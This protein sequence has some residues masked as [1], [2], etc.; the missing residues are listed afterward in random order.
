MRFERL[1]FHK[2]DYRII[3]SKIVRRA[4]RVAWHF[5][6]NKRTEDWVISQLSNTVLG[7]RTL[8]LASHRGG[9]LVT[10]PVLPVK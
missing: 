1:K 10:G 4:V 2:V 9:D 5:W 6:G 7:T 3:A 8:N